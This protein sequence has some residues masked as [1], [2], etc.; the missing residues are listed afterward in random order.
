L[1]FIIGKEKN[2]KFYKNL[3]KELGIESKL[4]SL[5]LE[6]MLMIFMLSVISFYFQLIM[7]HLGMLFLKQ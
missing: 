3:A 2:I 5:E 1:A 4:F 6:M 7:S